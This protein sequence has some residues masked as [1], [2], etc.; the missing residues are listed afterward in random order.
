[1][2][3]GGSDDGDGEMTIT[4]VKKVQAS[5]MVLD[6]HCSVQRGLSFALV[7]KSLVSLQVAASIDP[8]ITALSERI[9]GYFIE[10]V[11]TRFM[12]VNVG[13]IFMVVESGIKF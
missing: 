10:R 2:L 5:E 1:M 12:A 9:N 11:W 8:A 7:S 6:G 13:I 3:V 4:T